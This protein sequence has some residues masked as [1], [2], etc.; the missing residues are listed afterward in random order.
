MDHC[1]RCGTGVPFHAAQCVRCGL[2]RAGA[3]PFA[4][5][6]SGRF[7]PAAPATWWQRTGVLFA[8]VAGLT[9]IMV[10]A[11]VTGGL[12][13]MQAGSFG[14]ATA[15]RGEVPGPAVHAGGPLPG[16][17]GG[18]FAGVYSAVQSG[19]AL[20]TVDTCDMP[21]SGTGFLVAPTTVVTA[22]HVI[23]GATKVEVDFDGESMQAT[24]TGIAPSLDLAVLSLPARVGSRHVFTLA[25]QDPQPGTHIAVIGYPL[26]EPKSLTEGT[27]SGLGRTITTQSGTYAGLI[28]T[29]AAINPGNSGG[30]LLNGRGEVVGVA[31]AMRADAQGIGFAVPTSA[32]RGA[33]ESGVGL[34]PQE[35]ATCEPSQHRDRTGP[36]ATVRSY[37]RAVNASDYDEAMRLVG[38]RFRDETTR[39]EWLSDHATMHNDQLDVEWVNVSGKAAEVWAT[40]RRSHDAGYGPPGA[41]DATCVRWSLDYTLSRQGESWQIED[42]SGHEDPPWV[43]CD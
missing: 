38:D 21:S 33:I 15:A 23:D 39:A 37:L 31:D 27:I 35:A 9:A 3:A 22:A 36:R 30:P 40:H 18:D 42:I 41:E 29:D 17:P 25:G 4:A 6:P 19:V 34:S 16:Q 24:V 5:E 13:L 26:G 32:V 2:L 43:R 7:G 14:I 10:A 1:P 28:Q 8:V 20:I 12:W 11:L